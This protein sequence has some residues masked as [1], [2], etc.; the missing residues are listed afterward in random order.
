VSEAAAELGLTVHAVAKRLREGKMQGEQVHPRLWLIPRAEVDR[1]KARGR[2]KPGP[3][4]K[5]EE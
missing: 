1:W 3:K 4:R 2:L 5:V